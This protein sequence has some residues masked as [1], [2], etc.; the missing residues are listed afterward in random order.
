[1]TFDKDSAYNK[2]RKRPVEDLEEIEVPRIRDTTMNEVTPEEDRE[3]EE[4]QKPVDPP[5]EKNSYKRKSTWVQES[6]LVA[7]RYGTP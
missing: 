2:S 4:P 5:H 3:M 6:I 7:E 1:M